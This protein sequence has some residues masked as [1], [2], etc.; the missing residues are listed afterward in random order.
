MPGGGYRPGAGR[1]KS[2]VKAALE[3]ARGD[4]L[5]QVRVAGQFVR[6]KSLPLDELIRAGNFLLDVLR[7]HDRKARKHGRPHQRTGFKVVS[8]TADEMAAKVAAHA[9]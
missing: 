2:R 6:D 1:P 3:D 9:L 7:R 4:L 5:R 8:A